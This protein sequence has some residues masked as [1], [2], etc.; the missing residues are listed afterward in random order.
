[1]AKDPGSAGLLCV[2]AAWLISLW[3]PDLSRSL[4]LNLT[5]DLRLDYEGRGRAEAELRKLLN[6]GRSPHPG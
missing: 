3:D 2:D 4:V 6:G 5:T 1:M